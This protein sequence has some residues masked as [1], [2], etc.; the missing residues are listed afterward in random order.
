VLII[1]IVLI[2]VVVLLGVLAVRGSQRDSHMALRR[3][4]VILGMLVAI[5]AI[6]V[7]AWLSAV[8]NVVGIGRGA[9]LLLYGTV[10]AFI[11]YVLVDQRRAARRQ[12]QIT[13]LVRAL[14]L[15]EARRADAPSHRPSPG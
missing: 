10:I 5:L 1:Q 3:M 6:L 4:G 8:A 7:P 9:D 15:S 14:A 12:R 13:L 11:A 2:A